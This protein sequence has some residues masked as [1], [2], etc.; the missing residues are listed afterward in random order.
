MLRNISLP[1]DGISCCLYDW[2]IRAVHVYCAALRCSLPVCSLKSV[3]GGPL[4]EHALVRVCW[5]G[6]IYRV[7]IVHPSAEA[8]RQ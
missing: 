7:P 8:A 6:D 1:V 5:S 4:T 3:P 2:S